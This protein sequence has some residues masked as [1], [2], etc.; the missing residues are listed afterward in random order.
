[1]RSSLLP[2]TQEA[3][4]AIRMSSTSLDAGPLE[5]MSPVVMM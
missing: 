4:L 1:M 3:L 5:I 2:R